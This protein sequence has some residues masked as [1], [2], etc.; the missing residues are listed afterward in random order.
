MIRDRRG[1]LGH[2]D[3]EDCD[4]PKLVEALAGLKVVQIS[5]GGWHSAVVTD[6]VSILNKKKK[7]KR[8]NFVHPNYL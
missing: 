4:I 7:K 6:Q 3:L 1:Q 8:V 5:A 2:N